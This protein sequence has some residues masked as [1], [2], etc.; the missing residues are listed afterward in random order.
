M[1]HSTRSCCDC[2]AF[3]FTHIFARETTAKSNFLPNKS[4]SFV[5][6]VIICSCVGSLLLRRF[7]DDFL[8]KKNWSLSHGLVLF[9]AINCLLLTFGFYYFRIFYRSVFYFFFVCATYI[10]RSGFTQCHSNSCYWFVVVIVASYNRI[11][12]CSL[13]FWYRQM[14]FRHRG[15][16]LFNWSFVFVFTVRYFSSN[17]D[18]CVEIRV[19]VLKLGLVFC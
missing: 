12:W 17:W 4:L 3:S 16:C 1:S 9:N 19:S 13:P 15:L 5:L 6:L 8:K 10:E 7:P 18:F 14:D 11:S 2:V